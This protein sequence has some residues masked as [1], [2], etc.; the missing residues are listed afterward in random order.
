VRCCYRCLRRSNADKRRAVE[1][2]L[3]DP[4][5]M[6][7]SDNAIAKACAV[8]PRTVSAIRISANAEIEPVRT[9]ERGAK[10]S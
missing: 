4:E 8:S 9:V 1:T 5:W 3:A 10:P 6:T 2:L 7:W